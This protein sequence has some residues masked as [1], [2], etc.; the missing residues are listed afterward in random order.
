MQF[1]FNQ[2]SSLCR[3]WLKP[4]NHSNTKLS[5][6]IMSA[7]Y[8]WIPNII[9]WV[10]LFFSNFHGWQYCANRIISN[11]TL[12]QQSM[13][14]HHKYPLWPL[15]WGQ[16]H[17][18]CFPVPST[19]CHLCTCIF[20]SCYVQW[21]RRIFIYMKIHFFTLTLGSRSHKM[22]S[23]YPSHHLTYAPTKFEVATSNR[24]GGDAMTRKYIIWSL[25]LT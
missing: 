20:W 9:T 8:W 3:Q 18:K 10:S 22:L 25:T 1:C 11:R 12:E 24:L 13:V 6:W 23:Q 5:D 17:T 2:Q 21:C 7:L 19:S 4:W 14:H 15:L 16:G